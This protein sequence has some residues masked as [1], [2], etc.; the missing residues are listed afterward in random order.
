[1]VGYIPTGQTLATFVSG[2]TLNVSSGGHRTLSIHFSIYTTDAIRR[3]C[4]ITPT[5][6]TLACS[7]TTAPDAWN[8]GPNIAVLQPKR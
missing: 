1:M 8:G 7:T 3:G 4:G 6:P 2:I 5:P